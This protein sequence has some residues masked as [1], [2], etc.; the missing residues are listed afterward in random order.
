MLR[1][2]ID[3]R[4]DRIKDSQVKW[5]R[6]R[7]VVHAVSSKVVVHVK[8]TVVSFN[9]N[10]LL[11]YFHDIIAKM[12][13]HML[14]FL[15]NMIIHSWPAM[16]DEYA[17]PP[18]KPGLSHWCL[19]YFLLTIVPSSWIGNKP[20]SVQ[21][22]VWVPNKWQ[23]VIRI[24]NGRISCLHICVLRPPWVNVNVLNNTKV[25]CLPN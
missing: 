8:G 3:E 16:N 23:A 7:Q 13:N 11:T 22:S 5:R 1:A 17:K 18:F 25:V 4:Q 20:A 9:M 15:W 21:I 19:I 12:S 2:I 24:K 14:Y 6:S 10:S